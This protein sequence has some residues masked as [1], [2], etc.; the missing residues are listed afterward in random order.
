M[1]RRSG[2]QRRRGG[3][4]RRLVNAERRRPIRSATGVTRPGSAVDFCCENAKAVNML[5]A[6]GVPVLAGGGRLERA[7]CRGVSLRPPDQRSTAEQ[8]NR[9]G[10]SSRRVRSL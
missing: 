6:R 9:R 3:R 1:R 2:L 10:D 8:E 4:S 7:T 5:P